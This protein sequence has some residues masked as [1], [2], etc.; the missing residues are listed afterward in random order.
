[1]SKLKL[2]ISFKGLALLLAMAILSPNAVKL[3]HAFSHHT[4]EVCVDGLSD[5]HLHSLDLDCEFYKFKLQKDITF[6]ASSYSEAEVSTSTRLSG[7]LYVFS[8]THQ[9]LSFSLRAPPV[10]V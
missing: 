6:I 2:H 4:H 1:M 10:L 8:Y 3:T 7:T 9:H 5:T